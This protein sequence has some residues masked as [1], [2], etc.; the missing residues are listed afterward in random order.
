MKTQPELAPLPTDGLLRD[1]SYEVPDEQM[2]RFRTLT[3]HQRLHWL[4]EAR[5]FTLRC[6]KTESGKRKAEDGLPPAAEQRSERAP[7]PGKA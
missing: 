3:P 4:D 1:C 5:R 7:S 6:R 2:E